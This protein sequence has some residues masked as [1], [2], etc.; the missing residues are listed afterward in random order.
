MPVLALPENFVICYL[1]NR[2]IHAAISPAK[3]ITSLADN[4]NQTFQKIWV[5]ALLTDGMS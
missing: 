1:A 5:V 3:C 2:Q 4:N